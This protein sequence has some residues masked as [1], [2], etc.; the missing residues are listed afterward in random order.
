MENTFM[1][2]MFLQMIS[3]EDSPM[4]AGDPDHPS[5]KRNIH[6]DTIVW[7]RNLR[8]LNPKHF[9]NATIVTLSH[10]TDYSDLHLGVL[11]KMNSMELFKINNYNSKD[12]DHPMGSIS[13]E[14]I[15]VIDFREL[16]GSSIRNI[17]IDGVNSADICVDSL[18]GLELVKDFC[19]LSLNKCK[20]NLS[21]QPVLSK[22]RTL[23]ELCIS[24]AGLTEIGF[25]GSL[26][27]LI[28][29][30][31][32]GNEITDISPVSMCLKLEDL[33]VSKNQIADLGPIGCLK[34]LEVLKCSKNKIT[35]FSMAPVSL[36]YFH[37]AAM[38]LASLDTISHLTR[39][40]NV[41]VKN[42]QL[43]SL[44][45]LARCLK[46]NCLDCSNNSITSLQ[47][48]SKMLDLDYLTCDH[49]QI[50]SIDCLAPDTFGKLDFSY[51]QVSKIKRPLQ[52]GH[53]ADRITMT[54]NPCSITY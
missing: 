28:E 22:C 38:E 11:K 3:A 2:K 15:G 52:T 12:D 35:D 30:D 5:K 26:T 21:W 49:N 29:L 1:G 6:V 25:V 13:L 9:P 17:M 43:V 37:A 33:D 24:N 36:K 42:N 51:N 46:I 48:L 7:R 53:D 18:V 32:S 47:P 39:L 27:K 44:K 54:G 45:P 40:E 34:K 20:Y 16:A 4:I 10:V 31:V 41:D 50:T 19:K 8:G 14:P 23:T